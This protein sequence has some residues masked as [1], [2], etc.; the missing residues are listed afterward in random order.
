MTFPRVTL[1]RLGGYTYAYYNLFSDFDKY[2]TK[3]IC[4]H[5]ELLNF[6]WMLAFFN[7]GILGLLNFFIVSGSQ[8]TQN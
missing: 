3:W 8:L 6:S 4:R 5:L 2:T 7:L 1:R